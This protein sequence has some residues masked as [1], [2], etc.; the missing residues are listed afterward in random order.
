MK[1]FQIVLAATTIIAAT[2]VFAGDNHK[3]KYG[4]VVKE[5]GEIQYE[6]VARTDV[7]AIYVEDHGK[8]VDTA[9]ASSKVILLTNK[10]KSEVQLLPAGGNK[11]EAKGTFNVKPGTKAVAVVAL[12]AKPPATARFVVR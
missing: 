12:M 9:G 10:E 2:I 1:F 6:L 4:G 3:P 11:L 5:I 7:I 8:K